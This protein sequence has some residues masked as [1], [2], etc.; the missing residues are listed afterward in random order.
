[1][2]KILSI[3][4]GLS[5]F[6]VIANAESYDYMQ[7]S[8]TGDATAK[9]GLTGGQFLKIAHGARGNGMAGC[10]SAITNDLSS[11]YWNPAGIAELP[12]ISATFDYTDWIGGFSHDFASAGTPIGENFAIAV[13]YTSFS[14]GDMEYTTLEKPQGT[15]TTFRAS[16]MAIGLTLAGYLTDQF[17]FGVTAR[18]IDSKISDM[19]A[20]GVVF[21]VGTK[22]RTGIQG[23]TLGV[24]LHG[25]STELTYSGR[26]LNTTKK[27]YPPAFAT[28][29][30]ASLTPANFTIPIGFRAGVAADI[31]KYEQH[32][33]VAAFDFT[34]FS[35][36]PE[37][38]SIGAEYVWNNILSVRAGY[39]FGH[40][41]FGFGAGIGVKYLT[42]SFGGII[43]YSI[44][45]TSDFG[46][47]NRLSVSVDLGK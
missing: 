15:G 10:V 39:K 20:G 36:S 45:P 14:S 3:V 38:Y 19:S 47:V 6:T 1:M 33:V 40:D 17:T 27:L 13:H 37:Q 32:N 34:T 8:T 46:M 35:D 11:V 16:D 30:D 23:I 42:G 29:V 9:I 12:S 26:D 44:S 25:L 22:Y 41:V 18:Y 4:L 21:D 2:K 24:S 31:Y 5:L 7:S 43:D 28:D